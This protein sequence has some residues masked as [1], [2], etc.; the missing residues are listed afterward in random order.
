MLYVTIDMEYKRLV[1][2]WLTRGHD[3]MTARSYATIQ[4]LEMYS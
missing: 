4:L 2:F 3:I 1:E